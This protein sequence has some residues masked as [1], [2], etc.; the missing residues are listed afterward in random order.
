VGGGFA[1]RADDKE[2]KNKETNPITGQPPTTNN[3]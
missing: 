1:P 3:D 2:K